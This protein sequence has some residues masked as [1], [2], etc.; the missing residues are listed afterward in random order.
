M[1]LILLGFL[2]AQWANAQMLHDYVLVDNNSANELQLNANGGGYYSTA[3][4]DT[5][6]KW[7]PGATNA[8]G[9]FEIDL[10]TPITFTTFPVVVHNGAGIQ[11][12]ADYTIAKIGVKINGTKVTVRSTSTRTFPDN[13]AIEA[14]PSVV[15][16]ETD[17]T[18]MNVC[19]SRFNAKDL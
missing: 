16:V 4:G 6:L 11:I 3:S 19:Q 17:D 9:F 12:K 13:P 18:E 1:K 8:E 14:D 15:K 7:T 5:Q 10:S 2:A